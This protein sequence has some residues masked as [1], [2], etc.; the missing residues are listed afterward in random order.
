VNIN[1]QR[2]EGI[3]L[4]VRWDMNFDFGDLV[5]EAQ[6]TWTFE[7][8]SQ[9]FDP[10]LVSGF[11]TTDYQGTVGSPDNV[12][13]VR[14]S[15]DRNDWVFNYYLQYVSETDDSLFVDAES[16]YFGFDPAYYDITMDS[17]LYHNLSV[18]YRQDK[19]DLL[20]GINNVFD[21]EPDTVSDVYRGM[22]GGNK[23]NVPVSASQYD[24]LGRRVFVRFN[25][26][27]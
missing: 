2:V 24:L 22:V 26:R 13:N 16:T 9:L 1:K 12:T 11:D 3:D 21:E 5:V 6:S 10:D 15:L 14:F 23:S 19:W 27:L 4:N 8:T 17:V 25:W 18:I 7:N 20:V